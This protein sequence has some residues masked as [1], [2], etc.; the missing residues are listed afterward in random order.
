MDRS[1]PARLT[2]PRFI[3]QDP[4]PKFQTVEDA[5]KWQQEIERRR[6]DASQQPTLDAD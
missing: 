6:R 2:S 5:H 1:G 3:E 4:P